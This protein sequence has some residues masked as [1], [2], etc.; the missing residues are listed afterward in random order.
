M[1]EG[2]A[3]FETTVPSWEQFDAS[4]LD[5]YSH[6]AVDD[7]DTVLGWVAASLTSTRPCYAGVIEHSVYVHPAARGRRIGRLL[8]DRLIEVSEVLGIWTIQS[9]IFPENHASAALHTA[10]GFRAVGARERI[11]QHHGRWRDT[12][13]IERRRNP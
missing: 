1:D 3:T 13:N 6:G 9:S 11:A 2:N 12:L 5:A 7:K 10:A 4:H 8:L